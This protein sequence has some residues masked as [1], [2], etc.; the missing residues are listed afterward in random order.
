LHIKNLKAV[1]RNGDKTHGEFADMIENTKSCV[2]LMDDL[3][4]DKTTF[5]RYFKEHTKKEI[6]VLYPTGT[7]IINVGGQIIYSFYNKIGIK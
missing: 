3:G 7:A 4:A 5:P 2:F 6:T 1:A